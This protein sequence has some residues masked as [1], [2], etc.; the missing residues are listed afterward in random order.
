MKNFSIQIFSCEQ[1]SLEQL[2]TIVFE[3]RQTGNT[4]NCLKD[5]ERVMKVPSMH[6]CLLT[7]T[8]EKNANKRIVSVKVRS[9]I[10]YTEIILKI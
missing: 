3:H 2:E 9:E 1:N 7:S 4:F 10:D 5:L 8:G 6:N